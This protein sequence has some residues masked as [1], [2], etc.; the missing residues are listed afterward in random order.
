MPH[1]ISETSRPRANT[2]KS[3]GKAQ[4]KANTQT[5]AEQEGAEEE[6]VEEEEAEEDDCDL[7]NSDHERES[8]EEPNDSD[9]AFIDDRPVSVHSMEHQ[10]VDNLQL[11]DDVRSSTSVTEEVSEVVAAFRRP[12]GR[13]R[14][15]NLKKPR[16][17]PVPGR[18]RGRPRK[19]DGGDDGGEDGGDDGE[20]DDGGD[21]RHEKKKKRADRR[22]LEVS[23]E[24]GV[25]NVRR[26]VK[27]YHLKAPFF[28][29]MA[30]FITPWEFQ[31]GRTRVEFGPEIGKLGRG[32]YNNE[33]HRRFVNDDE[34][35]AKFAKFFY[36]PIH[37]NI[38]LRKLK[39]DVATP[40][41]NAE[42]C[43]TNSTSKILHA[44]T[45]MHP[46]TEL[47]IMN[48][49]VYE[50][51]FV[52]QQRT[53]RELRTAIDSGPFGGL[54]G[55]PVDVL[56]RVYSGE[57]I[58]NISEH[59]LQIAHAIAMAIQGSKGDEL[60]CMIST[61]ASDFYVRGKSGMS[62]VQSGVHT[63]REYNFHEAEMHAGRYA[64]DDIDKR[65]LKK[66]W[67]YRHGENVPLHDKEKLSQ[68][69]HPRFKNVSSEHAAT[70]VPADACGPSPTIDPVIVDLYLY[71]DI[72]AAYDEKTSEKTFVTVEG[73]YI[74]PKCAACDPLIIL[75]SIAENNPAASTLILNCFQHMYHVLGM[76]MCS[77]DRLFNTDRAGAA[78][79]VSEA[80]MLEGIFKYCDANRLRNVNVGG[81]RMDSTDSEEMNLWNKYIA[82]ITSSRCKHYEIMVRETLHD[83]THLRQA[84]CPL[85]NFEQ[86]IV[87][88]VTYWKVAV[89]E[90]QEEIT[91][92]A[93]SYERTED[94]EHVKTEL[95][96][97]LNIN[98]FEDDEA[99]GMGN[100]P[101]YMFIREGSAFALNTGL[102]IKVRTDNTKSH[103]DEIALMR[104]K[105]GGKGNEILQ[106]LP[107][108]QQCINMARLWLGN[109]SESIDPL[110][111]V[112][113]QS[114]IVPD[115]KWMVEELPKIDILGES[116]VMLREM[117]GDEV[118]SSKYE[119]TKNMRLREILLLTGAE[120][121]PLR[122]RLANIEDNTHLKYV[123][124]MKMQKINAAIKRTL[125]IMRASE[126][127]QWQIAAMGV[128]DL[129]KQD[130][131]C[132]DKWKA[133]Y[134]SVTSAFNDVDMD[135]WQNLLCPATYVAIFYSN[136]QN[137]INSDLSY[138][139]TMLQKLLTLCF[140]AHNMNTPGAYGMTL[141]IGDVACSVN[142][143]KEDGKSN[144][145]CVWLYDPKHPGMGIDQCTGNLA[146]QCNAAMIHLSLTK[147]HKDMANICV[148]T[149][150]KNVSKMSYSTLQGCGVLV[151]AKGE[152][153][154]G[155]GS[156]FQSKCGKTCYFAEYGKQAEDN[157]MMAWMESLMANSGDQ[158]LCGES[159]VQ[160]GSWTTT[161]NFSTMTTFSIK[162]LPI[163]FITGN[164]PAPA[165][166]ASAV[167]GARWINIPSS[168]M[169]HQNGFFVLAENISGPC[170][171]PNIPGGDKMLLDDIVSQAT[172]TNSVSKSDVRKD[173]K[174]IKREVVIRNRLH[175][176]LMQWMKTDAVLL[177]SALTCDSKSY[178]YTLRSN[179]SNLECS[180][181]SLTVG[182]RRVYLNKDARFWHRNAVGPWERVMQT[183]MHV[184]LCMNISL[185]NSMDRVL[186]KWPVSLHAAFISGVKTSLTQPIS[187][188]AMLTSLHIWLASAVLD[189]SIM[190]L[191]C[192]IYHFTGF[193]NTCSLRI[194]SLAF[195]GKL[196]PPDMETDEFSSSENND[197]WTSYL[198]FCE[199]LAPVVMSQKIL[200]RTPQDK[201]PRN[202]KKGVLGV[203]DYETLQTWA[204]HSMPNLQQD[205]QTS[206]AYR[207]QGAEQQVLSVY[208]KPRMQFV[209]SN[210][211]KGFGRQQNNQNFPADD[212]IVANAKRVVAT[213]FARE[214]TSTAH[215]ER[216]KRGLLAPLGHEDTAQFWEKVKEGTAMPQSSTSTND[217]FKIKFEFPPYTGIW[218]DETM[219]NTG[220]CDGLVKLFL[221]QSKLDPEIT[222]FQFFTKLMTPYLAHIKST[223]SVY[224][225]PT[226]PGIHKNAWNVKVLDNSS[227]FDFTVNPHM[228]GQGVCTGIDVNC[229]MR[230]VHFVLFQGLGIT[231]DWKNEKHD[232]A[233]FV[234]C[235]HLRNM[236]HMSLGCVGLLLHTCCDKAL[237]PANGGQILLSVPSPYFESKEEARIPY[238]VRL[239]VDTHQHLMEGKSDNVLSVSARMATYSNWSC[240]EFTSGEGALFY[241]H[242]LGDIQRMSL[243]TS[244][245]SLFPFAPE[246]V[247]HSAFMFEDFFLANRRYMEQLK[248]DLEND[249]Q[250]EQEQNEETIEKLFRN[251]FSNCFA[252]AML[253]MGHSVRF[254]DFEHRVPSLTNCAIVD[255]RELPCVTFQHGFIFTIVFK[256]GHMYI[257]PCSRTQKWND[258]LR[259][260]E[261][262]PFLPLPLVDDQ[263]IGVKLPSSQF[264]HVFR[265][266]LCLST[267]SSNHPIVTVDIAYK[268]DSKRLPFYMFPVMHFPVLLLLE[269][270]GWCYNGL[271]LNSVEYFQRKHY[272]EFFVRDCADQWVADSH[273]ELYNVYLQCKSLSPDLCMHACFACTE[274]CE[275][276]GIWAQSQ[277]DARLF[278]FDSVQH[279]QN[280]I[281]LGT[282]MDTSMFVKSRQTDMSGCSYLMIEH[283]EY[284]LA[285]VRYAQ[286]AFSCMNQDTQND[287]ISVSFHTTKMELKV[288][289]DS[290]KPIL[291]TAGEE[292]SAEDDHIWGLTIENNQQAFVEDGCYTVSSMASSAF[293]A[294]LHSVIFCMD[295]ITMSRCMLAEGS[296]IWLNLTSPIYQSMQQQAIEQGYKIMLPVSKHLHNCMLHN[297]VQAPRYLRGFYV[298]SGSLHDVPIENNH[299]RII[300][301]IK[302]MKR[303]IEDDN[304]G[305]QSLVNAHTN[306]KNTR[307]IAFTLPVLIK[308]THNESQIISVITRHRN[309]AAP[310]YKY[311]SVDR[312]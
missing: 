102:W 79:V 295:F 31:P 32:A 270:S 170:L 192:Y 225:G 18:G 55:K 300:C 103:D 73:I 89:S 308:S 140:M 88:G 95:G 263:E 173:I 134:L 182:L 294:K 260:H 76:P 108:P 68:L 252:L 5:E 12:R 171:K 114:G 139:N 277:N 100:Y 3:T 181:G 268:Q 46:Q 227:A 146:Q 193:Q 97:W 109:M 304:A 69:I 34:A 137:R 224:G 219:Q 309:A 292:T 59:M 279:I 135:S 291:L 123:V 111:D 82:T 159:G 213:M 30:D 151:D 218:W 293:H 273:P 126:M 232:N 116:L 177:C 258:L 121:N 15:E 107:Q 33:A 301:V 196:S 179:F 203:P 248:K 175:F 253:C 195:L 23:Y 153:M 274:S 43:R 98:Y 221:L 255:Q 229:C 110:D 223:D 198:E 251:K 276:N 112:F 147:D 131:M 214:Q 165:T 299:V 289:C 169:D 234:S 180:T 217:I 197:D 115:F 288:A 215:K 199:F 272:Q 188:M 8:D 247:A 132:S 122:D 236:S 85:E 9:N 57:E 168:T 138:M 233:T 212:N 163:L 210:P 230:L 35:Q 104:N 133:D 125:Q 187:F 202:V 160:Q 303:L 222:H 185:L 36:V 149:S 262:V 53:S 70:P 284:G 237:I 261:T 152:I 101:K 306:I 63:L 178:S 259:E 158:E 176:L 74:L 311:L 256:N 174:V 266:G 24:R 78:H 264:R 220:K 142:V 231:N 38:P 86:D 238:D 282:F 71:K 189:I 211:I 190:I 52:G 297:S 54:Q 141:R 105:K 11:D 200:N 285:P 183:S 83:R 204:S 290:F 241:K 249:F 155:V 51:V 278:H 127:K 22:Q 242:V 265:H 94:Q 156:D 280:Q 128:S 120:R 239:H 136:A 28:F 287:F 75:K 205:I 267:S 275:V 93:E 65:I 118:Y 41:L 119:V 250:K 164:R 26:S 298:L 305:A 60:W 257:R 44:F 13:P 209:S 99:L 245:A 2:N 47:D 271:V 1:T 145:T 184:Y 194:L 310:F 20:D 208:V 246:A 37:E 206:Y 207:T 87:H 286:E 201:G 154:S 56:W 162:K 283:S 150:L 80:R 312:L 29:P 157:T 10:E 244:R 191:A 254:Q 240:V 64:V 7:E 40:I 96:H 226:M 91:H 48:D 124:K 81:F 45:K 62:K 307:L 19:R 77:W 6:G 92:Y 167:E 49:Q 14:K 113:C 90:V 106:S 117:V 50:Q 25:G 16:A 61:Q 228:D 235:V 17:Q 130:R 39:H 27:D 143:L 84:Q 172:L 4:R 58:T 243:A 129:L 148:D 161:Q 302:H 186:H 281:V 72:F 296:E 67:K 66:V 216:C 144:R 21:I 269:H 166:P 42:K